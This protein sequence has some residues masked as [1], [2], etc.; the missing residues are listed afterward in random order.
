[1]LLN[2]LFAAL[3]VDV[4]G[5][6]DRF[7]LPTPTPR[8]VSALWIAAPALCQAVDYGTAEYAHA[9]RAGWSEKNLSGS[10][11]TARHVAIKAGGAA[12]TSGLTWLLAKPLRAPGVAKVFA[13]GSCG[14]TAYGIG[15]NVGLWNYKGPRTG[16]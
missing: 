7:P 9:H 11:G 16:L 3:T 1:M 15:S 13:A 2:L 12:L 14:I 10:I 6:L 8:S 5:H 4:A